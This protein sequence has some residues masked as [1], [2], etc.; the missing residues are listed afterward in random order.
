VSALRRE[1]RRGPLPRRRLV[2]EITAHL[3]DTVAELE[4]GGLSEDAA[5]HEAL[6]RL[7]HVTT[8]TTTVRDVRPQTRRWIRLRSPAWIAV[9]AMSFVMGWAAEL[10]QAS[11]AKATPRPLRAKH[12]PHVEEL[13]PG[14][15][16]LGDRRPVQIRLRTR[17]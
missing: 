11:G 17:A 7:G 5:V 6:R 13:R 14:R 2:A 15:G 3:D 9:G 16:G 1:L 8:I 10:P 4:A 12:A